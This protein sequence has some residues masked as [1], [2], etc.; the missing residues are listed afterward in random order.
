MDPG[1]NQGSFG[2]T[3]RRFPNTRGGGTGWSKNARDDL[4]SPCG[5]SAGS[6]L[7]LLEPYSETLFGKKEKESLSGSGDHRLPYFARLLEGVRHKAAHDQLDLRDDAVLNPWA[8]PARSPTPSE[9]T[10]F[11]GKQLPVNRPRFAL[12]NS[13]QLAA[14]RQN[15]PG[16]TAPDAEGQ[17]W[18]EAP[19]GSFGFTQHTRL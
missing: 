7:S 11:P 3:R 14:V 13:S 12:E 4:G 6:F 19:G 9:K 18:G 16:K 5:H 15:F 8:C 2:C 17:R 1:S 10:I